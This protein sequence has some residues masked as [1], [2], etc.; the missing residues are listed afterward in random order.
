[1]TDKGQSAHVDEHGAVRKVERITIQQAGPDG[2]GCL[3][4]ASF[5]AYLCLKLPRRPFPGGTRLAE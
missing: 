2:K 1:M 3:E 4:G 5:F